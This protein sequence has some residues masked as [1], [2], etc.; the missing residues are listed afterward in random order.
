MASTI[1]LIA[2]IRYDNIKRYGGR[3]SVEKYYEM[4]AAYFKQTKA[5]TS[6]QSC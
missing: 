1:K 5:D 4:A 2:K 3:R 6:I